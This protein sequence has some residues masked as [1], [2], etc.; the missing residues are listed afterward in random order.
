M[1]F[2]SGRAVKTVAA[3]TDTVPHCVPVPKRR[4]LSCQVVIWITAGCV[5]VSLEKSRL[6]C[7]TQLTNFFSRLRFL[8]FSDIYLLPF[9][10]FLIPSRLFPS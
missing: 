10:S 8:G 4:I 9:P 2:F 5:I 1:D 3:S 6:T 7:A